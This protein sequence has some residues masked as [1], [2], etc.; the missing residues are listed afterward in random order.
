VF[1]S[2][3]EFI[4]IISGRTQ[5]AMRQKALFLIGNLAYVIRHPYTMIKKTLA[6]IVSRKFQLIGKNAHKMMGQIALG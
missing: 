2:V 6:Q 5:F 1:S 4:Q 3:D